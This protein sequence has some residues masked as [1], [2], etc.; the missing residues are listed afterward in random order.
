MKSGIPKAEKRIK[1]K[2]NK[3]DNI[4]SYDADN[5]YPQ[6]I[7]DIINSSG[8][9]TRSIEVYYKFIIG[10]GFK[11]EKFYKSIVNNKG[12]TNDK[13]L[14]LSAIDYAYCGGTAFHINYNGLL[15]KT[16]ISHIP[17]EYCRLGILDK[18][19]MIAVY[20]NWDL[21]L[22]KFEREKI[23]WFHRY[24]ED[25]DVT[26]NQIL[27]SG[28]IANY[29]GQILYDSKYP[30][31]P[32][33]PV[34][35]DVLS[36]KSIK[37]FTQ[38]ELDNG[39]NPSVIGRYTKPF[40]GEEGQ[41][42]WE[43]T[44]EDWKQF[45]GAENTGKVFLV[46]GVSKDDFS[47]ERLGDSGADKM[48]DL[49]E[50]RVKNSIIQRFGQP[51][52]IVGRRDQNVTFSS[53]NIKDDTKFYNSVTKEERLYFEELFKVLFTNYYVNINQTNDYSILEIKFDSDSSVAPS[54]LDK[55]GIDGVREV[56]TIISGGLDNVQKINL[57]K[58]SF[59][60][61]TEEAQGLLLP[62][63]PPIV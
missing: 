62:I 55:I 45:Q 1:P 20:D 36:D 8:T 50:K 26:L 19:G 10:G 39:F 13:L 46:A 48:Y 34:L 24:S 16:N 37:L 3:S 32:I 41:K 43:E 53:Q 18:I 42:E 40:D 25:K 7:I 35:E 15:Q 22:G 23:K 60:L 29:G 21:S 28:G 14:Q 49:T 11:D 9:A 12:L 2:D 54:L 56:S 33:D 63:P 5:L 59:G 27:Q 17:F 57:L 52:S 58:L 47:L 31:A 6:R 61:T 4:L 51:P 38:K 44:N 30:L